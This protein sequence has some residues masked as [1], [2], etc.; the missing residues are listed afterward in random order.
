MRE[1]EIQ[2]RV[3]LAIESSR[4]TF[5]SEYPFLGDGRFS[6]YAI[7]SIFP[8]NPTN[9]P[10][11]LDRATLQKTLIDAVTKHLL[12]RC[13]AEQILGLP[14]GGLINLYEE[15]PHPLS[16]EELAEVGRRLGLWWKEHRAKR[17]AA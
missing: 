12:D 9:K 2:E 16:R 10:W 14:S 13:E 11:V 15:T 3:E 1:K 8:P 4:M 7:N 5:S 6:Y 17:K